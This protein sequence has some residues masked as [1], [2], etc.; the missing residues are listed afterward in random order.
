ME[1]KKSKEIQEFENMFQDIKS[2]ID[3]YGTFC[4]IRSFIQDNF[5][6]N[7]ELKGVEDTLEDVLS[8]EVPVFNP[9]A[10]SIMEWLI[11]GK[12]DEERHK[13]QSVG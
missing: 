7:S 1:K 3:N 10:D 13:I 2:G 11:N 9:V 8:E 5:V 6:A 4:A 12:K